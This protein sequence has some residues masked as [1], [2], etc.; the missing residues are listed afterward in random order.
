M[1]CLYAR[2]STFKIAVFLREH[3]I[4]GKT[5]SGSPVKT[6]VSF[7]SGDV[8]WFEDCSTVQEVKLQV[9]H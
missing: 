9:I 4:I 8:Q 1:I 2:L 3:C 7:P 5:M 6:K